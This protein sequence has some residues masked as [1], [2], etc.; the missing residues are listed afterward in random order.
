MRG[1]LIIQYFLLW[2]LAGPYSIR[3]A[4]S[5]TLFLEVPIEEKQPKMIAYSIEGTS[6]N[7]DFL[8]ANLGFKWFGEGKRDQ[9]SIIRG[10]LEI[11]W[12]AP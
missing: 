8:R 5:Q 1:P 6:K 2:Q 12:L 9:I 4:H 7:S 11:E 10:P 3:P